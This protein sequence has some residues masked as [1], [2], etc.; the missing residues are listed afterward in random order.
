MHLLV[1]FWPK[2]KP[3]VQTLVKNNVQPRLD[4]SEQVITRV[5]AGGPWPESEGNISTLRR[6]SRPCVD[7]RPRDVIRQTR[8][9]T[10]PGADATAARM[11]PIALA[12]VGIAA[13]S[14]SV[15]A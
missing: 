6:R 10:A 15:S 4:V 3:R 14:L 2:P 11:P 7:A 9:L 13:N 8:T 1:I 12:T 5:L